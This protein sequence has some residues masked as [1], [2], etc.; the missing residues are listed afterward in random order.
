MH[1][2]I[3]R[4]RNK[5]LLMRAVILLAVFLAGVALFSRLQNSHVTDSASDLSGP[6][7]P[8]MCIDR[9]GLKIDRMNGYVKEMDSTAMRDA[10]IPITTSRKLS[11]SY[12]AFK[13]RVR[14]V[15]YEV[16][17]PDSGRVVENAKIGGFLEDNGY[18]T[19][20]FQLSEPILMNREYPIRFTMETTEGTYYYY[21]SLIQRADLP[22]DR[23]V[24]F[25]YDFYETCTNKGGAGDLNTYL[26]YDN[27]ITNNSYTNVNIQSSLD[28]VTWGTLNPQ[29]LRK[30]VPKI[31]EISEASCSITND[32][33]ISAVNPNNGASEAYH[34]WE[35]YRLRF[36]NGRMMLLNFNRR[37]LQIYDPEQ[38]SAA[39]S[40]EG[41]FL[42]ISERNVPFKSNSSS[43]IAVFVQDNELWEFNAGAEKLTCV[44]SLRDFR[45]GSDERDDNNDYGIRII[46]VSES[47]DVDFV[48]WG[49]RNRGPHEGEMGVSVFRFTNE[50]AVIE[51]RCF[52]P[53]DRSFGHLT[54]DLERLS[55]VTKEGSCYLY[56]KGSVWHVSPESGSCEPVLAGVNPDC[57]TASSSQSQ[58]AWNNTSDP[59]SST[60]VT[61]MNLEDGARKEI[62]GDGDYIRALGFI[63]DDFIYGLASPEDVEELPAGGVVFAM[64]ELLIESFDGTVVKDYQPE[65]IW[66]S[67]VDIRGGL[68]ELT[69]VEWEDG[70]YV[71]TDRDDIMNN[72]LEAETEMTVKV[73]GGTRQGNTVTL[74]FPKTMRNLKP[75]I[76][77]FKLRQTEA[78]EI[79]LPETEE[80]EMPLYYVYGSG[81]MQA[82]LTDPMEAVVSADEALGTAL[83]EEGRYL[84]ERGNREDKK[85]LVNED[86]P[87]AF[88][89]EEIR[90][91]DLQ[92]A[93]DEGIEVLDLSGCT[94]SQVLYQVSQG[95]AVAAIDADGDV[96]LI[97]GYDR[98]NT[99]WVDYE[100]GDHYYVGMN[101]STESF[102][103]GGNVFVTYIEPQVTIKNEKPVTIG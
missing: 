90:A 10:L 22:V 78:R 101:D 99:R 44:Y 29:I 35:Y 5:P 20:T 4:N 32:Y 14:S 25:V 28:Q 21:A 33:L 95:R 88:F 87:D 72:K 19:A 75:L 39:V 89:S 68:V 45:E 86:I 82:A 49:Y 83:T 61:V 46:R 94:L 53:Y 18:M 102:E 41:A 48:V 34:V 92:E 3:V 85:E 81:S 1:T 54:K 62:S 57:F 98:Y 65:D 7:L 2:S 11:V 69:R 47:G 27:T 97:V 79:E 71:E 12:K 59:H 38:N 93:V 16:T 15:S 51:E 24:K 63:N 31:T 64:K 37:A 91:S 13:H 67:D 52:I 103:E 80:P 73:S 50:R 42:G 30:A 36:Y 58:I 96:Q 6:A 60:S 100:T 8:V 74:K 55:Y 66:V 77:R 40:T 56:L 84:Y 43:D 23:Y 26:E 76:T 17:A 9:N 70:Q